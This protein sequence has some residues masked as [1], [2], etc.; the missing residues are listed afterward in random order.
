MH[1]ANGATDHIKHTQ[2]HW[3][4][5]R[6]MKKREGLRVGGGVSK[7]FKHPPPASES[8]GHL[9]HRLTFPDSICLLCGCLAQW[10]PATAHTLVSARATEPVSCSFR[11]HLDD[12]LWNMLIGLEGR[13]WESLCVC[14]F[15]RLMLSQH[16][17]V[18]LPPSAASLKRHFTGWT[19]WSVDIT[20]CLEQDDQKLSPSGFHFQLHL[21]LLNK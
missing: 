18:A 17:P 8:K 12:L 15:W 20:E 14:L 13:R 11:T 5:A 9:S 1:Q 16:V 21:L 6:R 7:L 19:G 10:R 4:P 3:H 2:T